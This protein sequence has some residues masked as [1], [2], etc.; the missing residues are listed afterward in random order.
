MVA[1]PV[2]PKSLLPFLAD[3]PNRYTTV[4][5]L[6]DSEND[7][8]LNLGALCIKVSLCNDFFGHSQKEVS[9]KNRV[10]PNV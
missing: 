3:V 9:E 6:E 5:E 4:L 2:V 8:G 7:T 10:D 1:S